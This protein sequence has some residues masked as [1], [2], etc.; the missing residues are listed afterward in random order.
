[1]PITRASARVTKVTTATKLPGFHS[2]DEPKVIMAMIVTVMGDDLY[3]NDGGYKSGLTAVP[4]IY[5]A[6]LKRE[7]I[8]FLMYI[9]FF[10]VETS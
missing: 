8:N 10:L 2:P 7:R 3:E 9:I 4:F 1:M 5:V 6:T